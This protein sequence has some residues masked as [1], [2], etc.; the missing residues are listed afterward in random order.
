VGGFYVLLRTPRGCTT[1]RGN[2]NRPFFGGDSARC[3]DPA[4]SRW[5]VYLRDKY[6]CQYCSKTCAA[7]DLTLDHVVPR[8]RGGAAAWDNLVAACGECNSKKG[9]SVL[10]ELRGMRLITQ[11]VKPS[12]YSLQ[13]GAKELMP[14]LEIAEEWS[15]FLGV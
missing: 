12:F 13:N 11:P 8:S 5:N 10:K 1:L 9:N 3:V 14:S 15:D 7:A 4:L 6:S 2:L